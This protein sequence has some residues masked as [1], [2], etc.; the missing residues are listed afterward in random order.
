M[1]PWKA[2]DFELSTPDRFTPM[3]TH[4]SISPLGFWSPTARHRSLL[5]SRASRFLRL[6]FLECGVPM[7][8][9]GAR[10]GPGPAGKPGCAEAAS[11]ARAEPAVA[12][13]RGGSDRCSRLTCSGDFMSPL[14]GFGRMAQMLPSRSG[15]A[16]LGCELLTL[17][18]RLLTVSRMFACVTPLEY[19]LTQKC[20]SKSFG[21]HSY[22][23]I[24]LKLPWNDILTKNTGGE[25]CLLQ[26]LDLT[27][28]CLQTCVFFSLCC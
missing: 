6:R 5:C 27:R 13:P 26:R 10:T 11:A 19:A 28:T 20:A 14:A 4:S 17:G 18:S 1:R 24:G 8:P 2:F 7:D 25:G 16:S 9:I 12:D 23:I 15:L 21:I 3:S 22:K